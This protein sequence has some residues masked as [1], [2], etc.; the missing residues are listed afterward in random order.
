MVFLLVALVFELKPLW[1]QL[2]SILPHLI[3]AVKRRFSAD[4]PPSPVRWAG[5][6]VG[7]CL[8]FRHLEAVFGAFRHG[9]AVHLA[10]ARAVRRGPVNCAAV[11][12]AGLWAR[13]SVA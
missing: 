12:G 8:A 3:P 2:A 9:V 13:S 4:T 5:S 7:L 6:A 1:R 11:R 10:P